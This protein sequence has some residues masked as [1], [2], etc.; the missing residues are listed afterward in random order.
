MNLS[1]QPKKVCPEEPLSV[2]MEIMTVIVAILVFNISLF[3][4]IT[5]KI[6]FRFIRQ[7]W[8]SVD[9]FMHDVEWP[10]ML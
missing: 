8:I 2:G 1:Q 7:T 3:S 10:N 6:P 5:W 4:S 9:P